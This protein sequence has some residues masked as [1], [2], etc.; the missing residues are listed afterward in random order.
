MIIKPPK[1]PERGT[2]GVGLILSE[3]PAVIPNAVRNPLQRTRGLRVK[4]AMTAFFNP[5]HLLI[6]KILVQDYF[7]VCFAAKKN[8]KTK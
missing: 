5:V 1:S 7:F 4:P 6:L 2:F 3:R 8:Q